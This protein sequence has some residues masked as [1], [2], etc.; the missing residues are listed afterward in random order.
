MAI[1]TESKTSKQHIK[2]LIEKHNNSSVTYQ[3]YK[4]PHTKI[5]NNVEMIE[6]QID[7]LNEKYDTLSLKYKK[8]IEHKSVV[9]LMTTEKI[10]PIE[11]HD[12][13]TEK[14]NILSQMAEWKILQFQLM[15]IDDK[16]L[17]TA[18]GAVR[19]MDI[20]KEVLT[21]MKEVIKQRD[22]MII[23]IMDNKMKSIDEKQEAFK[24]MMSDRFEG[25]AIRLHSMFMN[26]IREIFNKVVANNPNITVNRH[27]EVQE[28][29]PITE[30]YEKECEEKDSAYRKRIAME[31][32]AQMREKAMPTSPSEKSDSVDISNIKREGGKYVC[33]HCQEKC[34][35]V[36]ML[37]S[38]VKFMHQDK[39]G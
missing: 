38:H 21:N 27:L 19:G 24:Q 7:N 35:N 17:A 23:E 28:H 1:E 36:K 16:N 25:N 30:N 11:L 33:P 12:M 26:N 20:E 14:E 5:L 22:D 34:E 13:L 3:N 4:E 31:K 6:A 32:V 10:V 8:A 39:E 29:H 2:E 9:N 37:N 18:L 15:E